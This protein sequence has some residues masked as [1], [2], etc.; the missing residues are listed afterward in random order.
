MKYK[1]TTDEVEAIGTV[2]IIAGI[3]LLVIF[4]LIL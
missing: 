3:V 4:I 2:L 1:K